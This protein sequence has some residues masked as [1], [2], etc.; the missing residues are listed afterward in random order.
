[1]QALGA[2]VTVAEGDFDD[3]KEQARRH[4]AA[5]PECVFVEDGEDDAITEGAGTIA[6]EL[7]Q[8]GDLDTVVVPLGDGA[9]ITGV[10]SWI[11]K[12]SPRTRIVGVCASGAPAMFESW[13]QGRVVATRS[14]QTI[15]DGIE[16]RV[17]IARSVERIRS[18]VDEIV[19]VDDH[20][21]IE[22]MKLAASTLGLLLE[23]SGAAG[24]A[25]IRVH[26]IPGDRIAT[27]LT[28]SNVHP[29]LL[30]TLLAQK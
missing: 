20:T 27:V 2:V 6:I 7:L 19:L 10:G 28:G 17:P 11:K 21:L 14:T 30:S 9:L 15:A 4:A 29:K 22:A 26:K 8:A 24:L 1:M 16:V 18:V 13:R 12:H 5:R 23:P 25:A 3:A